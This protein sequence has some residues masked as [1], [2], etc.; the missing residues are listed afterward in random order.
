MAV[1]QSTL[2]I[3][4][5]FVAAVAWSLPRAIVWMA[6]MALSFVASTMFWEAHAIDSGF[7]IYPAMFAG[8]CDTVV[9]LTMHKHAVL[10]WE[11]RVANVIHGMIF[12]NVAWQIPG[13]FH[14]AFGGL[15]AW[16]GVSE[17]FLYGALLDLGNW[18]AL[19]IIGGTAVIQ[20]GWRHHGSRSRR[21]I[22]WLL[23]PIRHHL[24]AHRPA[25]SDWR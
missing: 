12:V 7:F 2:L 1:Y 5:G 3:A 4:A 18:L 25:H 10:R 15:A 11:M 24:L 9:V 8:L 16:I 23:G 14:W 21:A 6:L 22:G 19:A 20:M 17:Q 13:L